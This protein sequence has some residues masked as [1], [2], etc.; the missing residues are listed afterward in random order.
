MEQNTTNFSP[1]KNLFIQIVRIFVGLL[2]IFSGLIKANDPSGLTYKMQDF[3]ELWN[4]HSFSDFAGTFS[5]LVITFEIVVGLAILLGY[6]VKLSSILLLLLMLFF[7]FLTSYAVWYENV[8]NRELACGCFG[9]CIPLKAIQSFWK[10]II[11]LVLVIILLIGQKYIRPLFSKRL[12]TIL[13]IAG[14]AITLFIQYY[15]LQH[16]PYV[17]CL[18]YKKGNNLH[19]KM[20]SPPNSQPDVYQTTYFYK[21]TLTGEE[22]SFTDEAFTTSKI[23]EDTTWV[24]TKDPEIKLISKG[25]NTPAIVGLMFSDFDGEDNT[26]YIIQNPAYTFLWF[27]RDVNTA[28]DKNI[29]KIKA[30]IKTA[31]AHNINFFLVTSST[32]EA[33]DA[34]LIKHQL[35]VFTTTVDQTVSKTI[36]RTNPGLLLLHNSVV[37]G[38][39]SYNDYPANFKVAN[40]KLTFIP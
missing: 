39:W 27:I 19:E 8:N 11:L 17:D 37:E 15:A 9:D 6:A 36:I 34:F 32:Q 29:D 24:S 20:Q 33:T 1:A 35:E 12:N 25:N 4:M 30:I 7:T 18:P 2:F 14:L 31:E 10:D 13:M 22:K 21:N 5:I 26:E 3:F 16:L 23:W 40:N 28:T 38:K